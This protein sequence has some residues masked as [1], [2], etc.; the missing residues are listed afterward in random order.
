MGEPGWRDGTEELELLRDLVAVD[1]AVVL[2]VQPLEN[3]RAAPPR[4]SA[5]HLDLL[6]RARAR[7]LPER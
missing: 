6:R 4:A 7:E 1:L 5:T 3:L 2:P